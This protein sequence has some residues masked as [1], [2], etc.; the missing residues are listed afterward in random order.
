VAGSASQKRGGVPVARKSKP[1]AGKKVSARAGADLELAQEQYYRLF[2]LAP[3]GYFVLDGDGEILQVNA[4]G[5]EQVGIERKKLLHRRFHVFV[6]REYHARLNRCLT[7]VTSTGARQTC[8]IRMKK[9]GGVEYDSEIHVSIVPGEA[10]QY[11]V[12]VSDISERKVTEVALTESLI[13]YRVLFDYVPL[14]ITVSDHA[15]NIT[16]AN[17]TSERLLGLAREVHTSRKI[18][19]AEWRIIRPDGSL[20]PSQEYPSVMALKEGRLVENVEMGIVR[21][22]RDVT[23]LSVTAAPI[24]LEGY[25]VAVAYTD[26]TAAKITEE[27]KK[28]GETLLKRQSERLEGVL[29]STPAIIMIATDRECSRIVGNSEAYRFTRVPFGTDL[30]KTGPDPERLAHYS[31]FRDGI[32]LAPGEMPIQQVAASG[33]ALTDH[34]IDLVFDDGTA[35]S[36][37]GNVTP[38]FDRSGHPDGAIAAFIDITDLKKAELAL[39]ENEERYRMLFMGMTEGFALHQIICNDDG[40]PVDYRFLEINPAFEKL[41]GLKRDAVLGKTHNEVLPGDN[42]VWLE[43]YGAVALTGNSVHFENYS[44][45]LK[46]HYEVFAFSP[47]PGQFAVLFLDITDRK[48]IEQLKEEF[49]GM[50]SH[51]MRTPLTVIIGAISTALTAGISVDDARVLLDDAQKSAEELANILENLLELSRFRSNRLF[52]NKSRVDVLSAVNKAIGKMEHITAHQFVADVP[53]TLPRIMADELRIE[54]ILHNLLENAVKYSKPSTEIKVSARVENGG[55]TIGV[56]D[57][58]RGI[59]TADQA[60]IFEQF[61]RLDE[62]ARAKGLGLGLVVCKRLVEAHC[63][64]IWVESELGRGSTFRFTLPLEEEN[65]LP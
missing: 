27:A 3:I 56:C 54:R 45:V 33:Q 29:E 7:L 62:P 14:G 16:E 9:R 48:H 60:K 43:R 12:A 38:L 42:P 15:G 17:A 59:A 10:R 11:L 51:E 22:D 20:M 39:R 53:P 24:P 65:S 55:V 58:G 19:S 37:I 2:D 40:K 28:L 57:H 26:I 34:A 64:R 61:E 44:P 4:A 47:S 46:K 49:I 31:I 32:E 36:L 52:I 25:G 21:D 50:V 13:K 23:W 41:T 5:C 35:R 1:V 63:G 6:T 18:G 30:S 8:E